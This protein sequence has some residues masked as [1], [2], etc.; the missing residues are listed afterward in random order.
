MIDIGEDQLFKI[1]KPTNW[2]TFRQRFIKWIVPLC[3][4]LTKM[5][6]KSGLHQTH[7]GNY[8]GQMFD[9]RCSL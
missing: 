6:R 4:I 3:M 7:I 8:T 9:L 5:Q 1:V 2:T